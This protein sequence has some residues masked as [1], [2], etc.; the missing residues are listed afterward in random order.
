MIQAQHKEAQAKGERMTCR[1]GCFFCCL[2]HVEAT[3]Q[4]CEVIVYYL[5]Q[6]EDALKS[7][8]KNYPRWRNKIR[9]NGDIF[10][11]LGE[12]KNNPQLVERAQEFGRKIVESLRV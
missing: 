11:E 1:K 5:Y 3:I 7:F 6:N 8:L 2:L 12:A 9:E 4:E 10:K